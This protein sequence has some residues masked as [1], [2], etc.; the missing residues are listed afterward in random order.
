MMV[1]A[2]TMLTTYIDYYCILI[3]IMKLPKQPLDSS[4]TNMTKLICNNFSEFYI[5]VTPSEVEKLIRAAPMKTSLIDHKGMLTKAVSQDM[6]NKSIAVSQD[7]TNKSISP[8][9]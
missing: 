6:T 3:I 5:L 2:P 7:M 8:T 1:T 9:G 4:T